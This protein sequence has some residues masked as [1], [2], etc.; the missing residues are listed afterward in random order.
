MTTKAKSKSTGLL[1]RLVS[2]SEIV[3]EALRA[4]SGQKKAAG[5]RMMI[6]CPFHDDKT[7]SFWIDTQRG[8]CGCHTC[9]M[10]PLDVI[11]L[12]ARLNQVSNQEAIRELGKR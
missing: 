2:N 4:Y 5:S 11:N 9:G 10:K 3:N 6:Q 7:P 1:T 12:F 8:L